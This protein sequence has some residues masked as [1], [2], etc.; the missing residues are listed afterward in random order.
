MEG[1]VITMQDVFTFDFGAGIDGDG[2]FRGNAEPT[3]VRPRF[4]ERFADVGI[5]VPTDVFR[6]RA[7]PERA[8]RRDPMTVFAIGAVCV[9]LALFVLI[10]LV[11][12]P[13]PKRVAVER[14][15]APGAEHV[16]ALRKATRRAVETIEQATAQQ[17]RRMFGSERLELA[18]IRN[19]ASRLPA[20]SFSR[21]PPCSASSGF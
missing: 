6:Y 13:P 1:D 5:S 12:A 14:R 7:R 17:D 10:F 8:A 19:G 21:S 3:G 20:S 16:S 9:L 11:I 15:L 18:G 2:R 4:V